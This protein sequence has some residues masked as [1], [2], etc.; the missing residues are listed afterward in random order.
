MTRSVLIVTT[1]T[2]LGFCGY[3]IYLVNA[4]QNERAATSELRDR[5]ELLEAAAVAK[6]AP[7]VAPVIPQPAVI[8]SA[9]AT[10]TVVA[11]ARQASTRPQPNPVSANTATRPELSRAAV[12]A[13]ME[14]Q[15]Q[16]LKDPDYRAAMRE[17]Q[18]L[19]MRQMYPELESVLGLSSEQAE[20]LF[21]LLA[22]QQMDASQ[23]R[24][25]A[26]MDQKQWMERMLE[27]QRVK[28]RQ[29]AAE[30]GTDGMQKWKDY[31]ASLSARF[32]VR[33]LNA[34]LGALGVPLRQDQTE[35][36]VTALRSADAERAS[37]N[38]NRNFSA[39]NR[40]QQLQLSMKMDEERVERQL[41]AV[42]PYLSPEQLE[43]YQKIQQREQ[44]MRQAS[45]RMME[46]QMEAMQKSGLDTAPANGQSAIIAAPGTATMMV[47]PMGVSSGFFAPAPPPP[48]PDESKR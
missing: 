35:T 11:P 3:C 18:K 22:D 2:T 27:Q 24:P 20:R 40:Q 10:A 37:S 39:T 32:Q 13:A 14:R 12:Q 34:Q 26:D 43:Q 45:L 41:E 47:T 15:Q 36:L 28:E 46:A 25:T 44:K 8:E 7:M 23:A 6:P 21:D 1:A 33:N 48:D 16:L 29:L 4:L 31:Q 19:G 5:I 38:V 30:L 9:A 17:Q 42:R